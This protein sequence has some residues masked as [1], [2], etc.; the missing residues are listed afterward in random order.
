M[1]YLPRSTSFWT[2]CIFDGLRVVAHRTLRLIRADLRA[3]GVSESDYKGV[4]LARTQEIGTAAEFLNC[5][6]L[7]APSARWGCDNLMLFPERMGNDA[8]LGLVNS[9][10]VDW[11]VWGK[12]NGLLKS[13]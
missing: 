8:T 9:E 13:I 11:I 5:D 2:A 4:N 1:K 12:D 7:I 6:G 3:L 10:S